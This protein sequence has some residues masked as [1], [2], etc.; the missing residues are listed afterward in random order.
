MLMPLGQDSRTER[1]DQVVEGKEHECGVWGPCA[2]LAPSTPPS[3][4]HEP[5]LRAG[6]APS[7]CWA[8]WSLSLPAPQR[9]VS[10]AEMVIVCTSEACCGFSWAGVCGHHACHVASPRQVLAVTAAA[11]LGTRGDGCGRRY[12]GCAQWCGVGF[13]LL[14]HWVLPLQSR[15]RA[16]SSPRLLKNFYFF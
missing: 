16:Q 2:L 11:I 12:T 7:L 15:E 1:I 10:G 5:L 8:A 3:S 4:A 6:W 9:L 14:S 13:D